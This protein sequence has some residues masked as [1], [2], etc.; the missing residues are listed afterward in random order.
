M[1]G[2]PEPQKALAA[3]IGRTKR[4]RDP[5]NSKKHH[6]DGRPPDT[7]AQ[8]VATRKRKN[9]EPTTAA[10]RAKLITSLPSV[11]EL[12]ESDDSDSS[13]ESEGH[14]VQK[15]LTNIAS[16][17]ITDVST[18]IVINGASRIIAYPGPEAACYVSYD[19]GENSCWLDTSL[20]LLFVAFNSK[21][22]GRFWDEL[23]LAAPMWEAPQ[24]GIPVDALLSHLKMR[25]EKTKLNAP[26]ELR[27]L[28][29]VARDALQV[30]EQSGLGEFGQ[31]S[32]IWVCSFLI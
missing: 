6:N 9:D 8:L 31:L 4:S 29:S 30:T 12:T 15:L 2:D 14:P 1:Y 32:S 7:T 23:S 25:Q 5:A 27:S 24:R 28:L 16:L 18:K 26:K 3:K 21:G 13:T 22:H 19:G 20:E 17:T 11:P 10:K